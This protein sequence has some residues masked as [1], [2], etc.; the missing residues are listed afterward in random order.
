M[1]ERKDEERSSK[2]KKRR[3][4]EAGEGDSLNLS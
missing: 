1:K 3:G 4:Q 2:E